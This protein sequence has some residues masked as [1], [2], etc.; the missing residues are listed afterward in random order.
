MKFKELDTI[1]TTF[2]TVNAPGLIVNPMNLTA[3]EAKVENYNS[4]DELVCD[5]SWMAHNSRILFSGISVH[6]NLQFKL[7]EL[8]WY[9]PMNFSE[10][11]A[12]TKTALDLC[13][14]VCIEIEIVKCCQNCFWNR[15]ENPDKW[16]EMACDEPHL[17]IFAK[18]QEYQLWPAKLMSA[19]GQFA[20]IISFGNHEH[21]VV[22]VTSCSLYS[23]AN[24]SSEE[25]ETSQFQSAINVSLIKVT[26]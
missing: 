20:D 19:N 24:L 12:N 1:I 16:F 23:K 26:L 6:C 17:L 22:P 25:T 10:H 15:I 4:F 18:M 14:F 5:I 7:Y 3:I 8:M 2:Q 21:S 9:E 13:Q 11:H